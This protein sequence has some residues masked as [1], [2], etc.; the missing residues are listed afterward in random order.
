M[1]KVNLNVLMAKRNVR[2]PRQF[3]IKRAGIS[4]ET[5]SN[6][7]Q[8]KVKSFRLSYMS[9]ICELLNCT[10]NDLLEWVPDGE[11]RELPNN[12]QLRKIMNKEEEKRL[13]QAAVEK[14]ATM[15]VDELRHLVNQSK[16]GKE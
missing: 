2:H 5:A 15:T 1:L 13:A 3:L 4:P 10:P 6:L 11:G 8:G 7:L 14:I 12:H 9:A 16:Q